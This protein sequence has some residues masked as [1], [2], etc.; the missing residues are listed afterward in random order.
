MGA[1]WQILHTFS[2]PVFW[3]SLDPNDQHTMYAS[4]AFLS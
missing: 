2:H 3:V 1:T 4:G